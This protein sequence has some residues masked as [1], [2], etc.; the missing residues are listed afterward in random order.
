MTAGA[1]SSPRQRV[2]LRLDINEAEAAA[3]RDAAER[4]LRG[5]TLYS[6][7]CERQRSGIRPANGGKL[8]W[9]VPDAGVR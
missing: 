8:S 6:I 3:L 5:E 9:G 7:V 1:W 2:I 4:I